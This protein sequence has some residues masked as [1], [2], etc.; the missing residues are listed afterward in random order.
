MPKYFLELSMIIVF[1][2]IFLV[3]YYGDKDPLLIE[4][5]VVIGIASIRL[6]PMVSNIMISFGK[7]KFFL[8][9]LISFMN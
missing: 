1:I 9:H 8:F 4:K 2:S 5:L 6:M 3:N 7:F